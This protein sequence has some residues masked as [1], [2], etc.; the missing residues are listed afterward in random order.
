MKQKMD[1]FEESLNCINI[2]NSMTE[3]RNNIKQL[4]GKC[5]YLIANDDILSDGR[6][7]NWNEESKERQKNQLESNPMIR[8]NIR[9]PQ[10]HTNN[11]I[12]NQNIGKPI[13]WSDQ[14]V[15]DELMAN[16]LAI[17]EQFNFK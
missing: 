16:N 17:L 15:W 12:V 14:D 10:V 4:E 3:L 8:S 7:N 2:I 13:N 9:N 5:K 6:I 11:L 1:E